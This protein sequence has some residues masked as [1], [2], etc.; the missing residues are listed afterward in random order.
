MKVTKKTIFVG[1]ALA[2]TLTLGAVEAQVPAAE[3]LDVYV[4][5][6]HD[7]EVHR[8]YLTQRYDYMSAN[9]ARLEIPN[10]SLAKAVYAKGEFED[11]LIR[12]G[13]IVQKGDTTIKEPARGIINPLVDAALS[14]E[15]IQTVYALT[16]NIEDFE[17]CGAIPCT[18]TTNDSSGTGAVALDATSQVNGTNSLRCD[19]AA[20]N[21]G[22]RLTKTLTS[23][24]TY[25]AQFYYFIP[26]GFTFG[27]NGYTAL[28]AFQDSAGGNPVRCTIE[29]YGVIRIT[30][31]G[32]ELGYT[33]TSINVTLNTKTRLE[34]K[35][36]IGATT[37]D[38]DIW[39]DSTTEGSP[40]YNGSGTL[41][42]GT[43]NITGFILGGYHPDIVNDKFY[44]DACV[45]VAF[46]G[47]AC[48]T[49]SA[50]TPSM[51]SSNWFFLF[52]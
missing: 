48:A 25:Y 5:D 19:I 33:D 28:F 37:G 45:D 23:A 49:I 10:A 38:L 13:M 31:A 2:A 32:D 39:K 15:W 34:F 4:K 42:T 21:D 36:V 3:T 41:N 46:M 6:A 27:A 1:I 12:K 43:Q 9:Q 30:C 47:T 17:T 51:E 26:T 14:I 11:Y 40:T 50:S 18:F 35:A 8:R 20:A 7:A 16:F 52:E 24:S 22:C 44:D 29:D